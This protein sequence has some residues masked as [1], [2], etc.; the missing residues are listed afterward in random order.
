MSFTPKYSPAKRNLVQ[1]QGFTLI[2]IMV[3]IAIAAILV[4]AVALNINFRNPGK[5]VLQ[6]TQRTALLMQLASDQAV[7][8]RQ[9]YGI[10]FHPESYTFFALAPDETG[11]GVW[12]VFEDERLR[13]EKPDFKV[14]FEVEI[15]GLP[16]VLDELEVELEAQ[17][18]EDPIRPHVMFL[19]NGEMVPDFRVLMQDEEANF[20]HAVFAGEVLPIEVEA[21]Q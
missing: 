5:T 20:R 11:A 8:S 1:H 16:I 13:F 3:V 18:D 14:E 7:Y 15:S 10:R 2:E 19:S 4:G 9:Q 21:I 12:Q 17:T 6:T